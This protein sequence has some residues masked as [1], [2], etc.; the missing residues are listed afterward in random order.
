MRA[1][2]IPTLILLFAS[3]L[4]AQTTLPDLEARLLHQPLY[5]SGMWHSDKLSFDA[6]GTFVGSSTTSPFTLS[7]IEISSLKLD[8]KGLRIDGKRAGL[9]FDKGKFSSA[10]FSVIPSGLT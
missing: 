2:L 4:F 10:L 6:N 9:E 7:G 5:L 3:R 8:S 1:R